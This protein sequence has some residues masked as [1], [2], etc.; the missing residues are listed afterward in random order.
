MTNDDKTDPPERAIR[1]LRRRPHRR[2][3]DGVLWLMIGTVI[4]GM[5]YGLLSLDDKVTD[6]N[7]KITGN[8]TIIDQQNQWIKQQQQQFEECKGSQGNNNPKCVKPVVPSVTLTPQLPESSPQEK[9]L[10]EDQVKAIATT[11]VANSTWSPTTE[12]TQAI[13]RIAYGMIPKQPTPAQIQ[14]MLAA[15]VATYCANDRCKGKDAPT[16]TPAPGKDGTPG[17]DGSPGPQ[18]ERGPGPT[19]EQVAAGV[20]AFCAANNDCRGPAGRGV[21]SLICREED[22]K[23]VATYT[24]DTTQ[25]IENSDCKVEPGPTVTVTTTTTAPPGPPDPTETPLVKVGR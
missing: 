9:V 6:A 14:N 24:D 1:E 22:G 19:D 18:G 5:F 8:A 7:N 2:T 16:I 4:G 21:V 25:V 20:A 15:T 17:A 3:V 11:V 13:A 10:S 23:L 12:Q